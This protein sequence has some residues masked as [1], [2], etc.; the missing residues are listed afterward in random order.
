MSEKQDMM[1]L[2]DIEAY[3]RKSLADTDSTIESTPHILYVK[4]DGLVADIVMTKVANLDQFEQ[5]DVESREL[6]P[7]NGELYAIRE[8]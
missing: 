3:V 6:H 2:D 7:Q 1:S 5:V 8:I 4:T